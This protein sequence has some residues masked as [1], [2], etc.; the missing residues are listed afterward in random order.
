MRRVESVIRDRLIWCSWLPRK[1]RRKLA[2]RLVRKASAHGVIGNNTFDSAFVFTTR[3]NELHYKGTLL[4]AIDFDIYFYGAFE[5]PLANFLIETALALRAKTASGS[6]NAALTF[7]DVG[8]NSGQH[9][10]F[11]SRYV[12]TVHAFE[13][14]P[15]I[16]NLLED[17]ISRNQ[18]QNITLHRFGLA[19][20]D[21]SLPFYAPCGTNRGIGSFDKASTAK[22]NRLV[23]NI[24]VR[25]GDS[26]DT[27]H[28]PDLI[29]IDVEGFEKSALKGLRETLIRSR[30]VIV[31]EVSYGREFS[32]ASRRDLLGCLPSDYRLFTFDRRRDDGRKTRRRNARAK[33]NGLFSIKPF[34][35]WREDSQDDLIA[36]PKEFIARLPLRNTHS[37][38]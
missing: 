35:D 3:I 24:A 9:A 22:G 20:R 37:I 2:K 14:Y 5:K 4:D 8:A 17:N 12:E 27:L 31:L 34:V 38:I 6:N 13:P 33:C 32:F 10:L 36:C 19:E 23:G 15:E 7:W 21:T 26:L 28:K 29:K 1:I 18:L 25:A 30:P 11:L 16:A